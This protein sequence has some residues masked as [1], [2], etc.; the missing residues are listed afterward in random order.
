MYYVSTVH[1]VQAVHIFGPELR[2]IKIEE[3]GL[4]IL[5]VS[6]LKKKLVLLTLPFRGSQI[7][8]KSGGHFLASPSRSP[9]IT[10]RKIDFLKFHNELGN[11]RLFG[12]FRAKKVAIIA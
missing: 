11:V 12:L 8:P 1:K 2:A 9:K 3:G 7:Y 5:I 10:V 6:K 4:R